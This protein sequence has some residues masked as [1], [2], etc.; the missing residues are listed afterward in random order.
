VRVERDPIYVRDGRYWTSAGV[1]AG[2]DLALALVEAD[3]GR[4]V[5]MLVAR[6]LVVFVRR[7]GGQSQFSAALAGQTAERAPLR[8]LQA[9]IVEHPTA[10]LDVPSLARRVALSPRHFSR[11]FHA[12]VGMPPARFVEGVRVEAARSLLESS[13]SNLEQ[14]AELTGFGT[15]ESLRRAFARRVGLSPSEYRARFGDERKPS[16]ES[17]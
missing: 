5:A 9:Y 1:T 16:G 7:V 12:E 2:I 6:W 11:A 8:D 13:R 3:V 4:K 10:D 17:S 15:P 14:V